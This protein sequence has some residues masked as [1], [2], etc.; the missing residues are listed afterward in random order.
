MFLTDY[1]SA[2]TAALA[3]LLL[4]AVIRLFQIRNGAISSQNE[5]VGE[6]KS[7][8]D[9]NELAVSSLLAH[10]EITP[11]LNDLARKVESE[12][13]FDLPQFTVEKSQK[14]TAD[15]IA[16]GGS[17]ATSS[18]LIRIDQDLSVRFCWQGTSADSQLEFK[19]DSES[20]SYSKPEAKLDSVENLTR[21]YVLNLRRIQHYKR[22]ANRDTLTGL[23]NVAYLQ[24]RLSEEVERSKRFSR[25]VGVL[26]MDI[27]H[28]KEINDTRGHLQGDQALK[29]LSKLILEHVR[30]VDI[31]CRY[32]GDE[33]CIIL[34]DASEA[35]ILGTMNRLQELIRERSASATGID[36]TVS[37]GGALSV[38]GRL[39][40]EGLFD[41]ADRAM[42]LAKRKGRNQ[43]YFMASSDSEVGLQKP[44]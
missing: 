42:L 19:S 26:I 24:A 44:T 28:F 12:F 4:L 40:P 23:Y 16:G 27:D 32:G 39:S 11:L 10:E 31:A 8:N 9:A 43:C 13:G 30:A 3:L 38:L 21:S 6:A 22:L 7:N 14:A 17:E 41:E 5:S 20:D 18:R 15:G 35:T 1:H 29:F 25:S 33:L 36:L 37:I 34:P 2:V